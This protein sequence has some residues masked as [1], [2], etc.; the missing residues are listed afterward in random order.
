[1]PI[2]NYMNLKLNS[3]WVSYLTN[4]EDVSRIIFNVKEIL[5]RI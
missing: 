1:M 4:N 2:Y 3:K 5:G